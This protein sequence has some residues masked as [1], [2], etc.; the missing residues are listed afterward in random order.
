VFEMLEL[1][2]DTERIR[3]GASDLWPVKIPIAKFSPV[4]AGDAPAPLDYQNA[5]VPLELKFPYSLP[6]LNRWPTRDAVEKLS[7]K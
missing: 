6:D 1:F 7:A 5:A 4:K 2:A 3:G